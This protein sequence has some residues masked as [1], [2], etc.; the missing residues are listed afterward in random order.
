ME[1]RERGAEGGGEGE[2]S[3]RNETKLLFEK[4]RSNA[5]M[6]ATVNEN[7]N[8]IGRIFE[9]VHVFFSS[10]TARRSR[11]SYDVPPTHW[12]YL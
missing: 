10:H 3:K 7:N 11:I 9:S 2:R 6:D 1:R 8:Y 5:L 4:I 12:N